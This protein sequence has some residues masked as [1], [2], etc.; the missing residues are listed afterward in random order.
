MLD[1][2]VL[3]READFEGEI[4]VSEGYDVPFDEFKQMVAKAKEYIAA[5]DMSAT[6]VVG[7][8]F[9]QICRDWMQAYAP[10][11]IS[12][13]PVSQVGSGLVNDPEQK[14][15]H[16]VDVAAF[17]N[18]ADG[19]S[20]VTTQVQRIQ[21]KPVTAALRRFEAHLH[22]LRIRMLGVTPAPSLKKSNHRRLAQSKENKNSNRKNVMGSS[23][24]NFVMPSKGKH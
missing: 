18:D 21:R 11:E 13:I 23:L 2:D 4:G 7:P 9:E 14:K 1:A 17:G 20:Q 3:S 19:R 15:S 24:G 12:G 8:R 6:S 22:A 16:Q 5:G 10:P